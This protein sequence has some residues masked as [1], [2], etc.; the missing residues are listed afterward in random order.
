MALIEFNNY[1]FTYSGS[2]TPA[3]KAIKLEIEEGA[4]VLICGHTGC[5][6]TTL[7]KQL[8]PAIAPYGNATGTIFYDGKNINGYS[9]R[10]IALSFGYVGQNPTDQ[11][12]TDKVW[13]EL[14]FGME[15]R[16]MPQDIMERRIAEICEFFG[17]QGSL[18]RAV[19]TLSGGELQMLHLAAV[20]VMEPRVLILDEPT[21][22]LD[23]LAA[24]NLFDMVKRVNAELGTTIIVVEHH[25]EEAYGMAD[26]AVAMDRACIN[27]SGT[28]KEV[29]REMGFNEGLPSAL[30]IAKAVDGDDN[31]LPLTVAEGQRW[32]YRKWK[33]IGDGF[34][35]A[36]HVKGTGA[37]THSYSDTPIIKMTDVAFTYDK[38][39]AVLSDCSLEI[40]RGEIFALMGGNGTGKSTLLKLLCADINHVYGRIEILGKKIN[41]VKDAPLGYRQMVYMPQEAKALITEITVEEEL[42]E[43]LYG[44]NISSEEKKEKVSS[45]LDTIGLDDYKRYHPYDLSSGQQQ[46][47]ALGK[48]LLLEPRIILMDEPTKGIDFEG[49]KQ[50]AEI[51]KRLSGEGVTIL[52]ASHDIEFCARYTDRCGLMHDGR[53][54]AAMDRR[55]FF[56]GNSF[57]TTAAN[58]IARRFIPEAILPEEVI[59]FCQEQMLKEDR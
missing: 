51:I 39:N 23:P 57:F 14:A 36:K 26:T 55:E 2:D 13:H 20:M 21:A 53:V 45:M 48:L 42:Q 8:I 44:I 28:P 37:V 59:S 12:V 41:N 25:L 9:D 58:R 6:K 17:L 40:R 46:R 43:A 33:E 22:Q 49:K 52:M 3:L 11:T 32:L 5:G 31:N 7:V 10:D 15:N 1:T 24:R 19:D 47:L 38:I 4:F 18:H 30:R 54:V 56:A 35:S 16:G 27:T 50:F 29:A 34:L